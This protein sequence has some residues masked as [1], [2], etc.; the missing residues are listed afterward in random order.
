MPYPCPPQGVP[1][2]PRNT[3]SLYFEV[4]KEPGEMSPYWIRDR[5]TG[6]YTI[7]N[8]STEK[9]NASQAVGM[10]QLHRQVHLPQ[11][12]QDITWPS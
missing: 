6:Q 8:D 1:A 12:S 10:G 3:R 9:F 4:S 11:Q 7:N 2:L 5:C